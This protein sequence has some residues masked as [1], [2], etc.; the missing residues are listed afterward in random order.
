MAGGG[1]EGDRVTQMDSLD[2]QVFKVFL[3]FIFTFIKA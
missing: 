3:G 2:F 1:R